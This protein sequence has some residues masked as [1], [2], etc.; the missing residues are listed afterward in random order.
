MMAEVIL[1]QATFQAVD[2]RL[3]PVLSRYLESVGLT[4]EKADAYIAEELAARRA[5]AESRDLPES[6]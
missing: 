1:A 3:S 6:D 5:E 2:A 4:Q